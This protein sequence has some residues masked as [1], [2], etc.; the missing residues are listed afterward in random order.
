MIQAL[1]FVLACSQAAG[2]LPGPR[3]SATPEEVVIGEPVAWTLTVPH[4]RDERL[5]VPEEVV[6]DDTW[7]LLEGPD[8]DTLPDALE[9][10]ATTT[11]RWRVMSLVPGERDLPVLEL[12]LESGQPVVP[13]LGRLRVRGELDEEE[14]AP[15]PLA[16]FHAIEER[17]RGVRIARIG[18]AAGGALVLIAG[19]F[20]FTRSRKEAPAP[21]PTARQRLQALDLSEAAAR[22]TAAGLASVLRGAVEDRYELALAGSTDEEWCEAVRADGRLAARTRER[23]EDILG[24]SAEVRF[25]HARPT[26]FRI[27]EQVGHAQGVL[28]DLAA[29]PATLPARGE[30]S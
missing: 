30:E 9:D 18:M 21:V 22:D 29:L 28:D 19:V 26:R 20:L 8:R 24:W 13:W 16:D 10:S 14:D 4:D 23:V 15:R 11:V 17:A 2:Q 27:E 3:F 7:V 6:P 5:I 25:G 1:A 12:R